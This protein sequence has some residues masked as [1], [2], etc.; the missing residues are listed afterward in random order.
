LEYL[1]ASLSVTDKVTREKLKRIQKIQVRQMRRYK[2]KLRRSGWRP[3]DDYS[4]LFTGL[5][6]KEKQNNGV[7]VW[8]GIWICMRE[9]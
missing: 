2:M 5:Y 3:R 9:I 8:R 1:K 4:F 7:G 6:F